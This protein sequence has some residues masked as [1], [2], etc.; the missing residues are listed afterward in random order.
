MY[1]LQSLRNETRKFLKL[2]IY[3]YTTHKIDQAA[4][5]KWPRKQEGKISYIHNL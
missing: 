1:L 4:E 2:K 5:K 3:H